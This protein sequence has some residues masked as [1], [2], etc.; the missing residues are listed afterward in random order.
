MPNTERSI[1][2]LGQKVCSG[3]VECVV[4]GWDV[5]EFYKPTEDCLLL[6]AIAWDEDFSLRYRIGAVSVP[7]DEWVKVNP[8]W[9]LFVRA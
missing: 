7:D 3:I 1:F 8:S 4:V 6:F 9:N 2:R 5:N